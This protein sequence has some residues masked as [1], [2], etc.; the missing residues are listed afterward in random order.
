MDSSKIKALIVA[1]LAIFVALYLGITAATAQF[2]TI[3]WVLGTLILSL[4]LFLGRKIWLI[5]P[6]VASLELTLMVP[7]RP[8]IVLLGQVLFVG[9]AILLLLMRKLPFRLVISEL[10]FWTLLLVLCVVQVYTRNPTGIDLLGGSTVGGRPYIIFASS[11]I[12]AIILC[13]IRVPVSELRLMLRLSILG[14]ILHMCLSVVGGLI[15][16]LG[17]WYGMGAGM[18]QGTRSPDEVYDSSAATRLE[19]LAVVAPDVA[20]W[21]STFIS[22]LKACIKPLWAPL[23]LLSLGIAAASG[24]RNVV[25]AVCLT[26]AVGVMYRG[27]FLSIVASVLAGI[28]G[29]GFLAIVNLTFPLPANIQRSLSFLPGT[30]E[31]TYRL[32]AKASSDWRFEMWE[33]VL[34]T[35][36]WI[37]NKTF[38]DGLGFTA[39][40]L[41]TQ[42]NLAETRGLGLSG[43]DQ[44]RESILVNGD[45]HSGPVSTIRTI[46][47]VGLAVLL[48]AKIRLA[49]H[50]HRQIMR[51]KGTEWF[52]LALFTGIPLIWAPVFFVFI[53]GGFSLDSVSFLAGVAMIRLLENN[54]PLPA[55]AK[56]RRRLQSQIP[57]PTLRERSPA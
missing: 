7:G 17:R 51:C 15:P 40:E 11:L 50:A 26:Y 53:F 35:D 29:L 16:G 39:A 54:L 1:I 41:A 31:Q 38:G 3:A 21:V 6:F 23:V 28:A 27:G 13:G 48:L 49:V 44:Q 14:G 33:E 43:F 24:F 45:Y 4:C 19:F 46:G 32:D 18:S 52:T 22:P 10:E 47:Y 20:L 30:W 37:K 55:Y 2:E 36:R 12:A 42:Q 25:G 9:F 57:S 8:T 34:T 5:I 56:Q